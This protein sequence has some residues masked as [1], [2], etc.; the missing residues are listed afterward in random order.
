MNNNQATTQKVQMENFLI[1]FCLWNLENGTENKSS[2]KVLKQ[3]KGKLVVNIGEK[4]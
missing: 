4:V 2:K 3:I 1:Q